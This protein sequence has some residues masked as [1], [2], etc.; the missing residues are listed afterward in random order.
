MST[1]G[2]YY[3]YPFEHFYYLFLCKSRTTH[4]QSGQ[5]YNCVPCKST[6]TSWRSFK[7][8]RQTKHGEK[9]LNCAN[10]EYR[11]NRKDNL[12]RHVKT[13]HSNCKMVSSVIDDILSNV[14]KPAYE[15]LGE[16][17]EV[18]PRVRARNERV[19]MIQAEFRELF[20][21]FEQEVREL[22]CSKKQKGKKRKK[23]PACLVASKRSSRGV[24]S[25]IRVGHLEQ[26]PSTEVELEVSATRISEELSEELHI[27]DAEEDSERV[28]GSAGAG[29]ED[30]RHLEMR[31]TGAEDQ[32]AGAAEESSG[33]SEVRVAGAGEGS[34]EG[35][36]AGL[37]RYGCLPCGMKFRDTLNLRRHVRLVHEARKT[38]VKCPRPWCKSQFLILTEM[39]QHKANCMKVCP[40]P[41]CQRKFVRE[42][43]FASHERYHM[44][45]VRRMQDEV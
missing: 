23:N 27:G 6:F 1:T 28:A 7:R 9:E 26:Q 39:W 3:L 40:F 22:G 41:A 8:H 37:G 18:D 16:L 17:E 31:V 19:A 25:E 30:S 2:R 32:V 20:P 44:T 36:A 29:G 14:V 34:E 4:F 38:P 10:C 42:D 11:T 24:L 43:K 45:M 33:H 5:S 35:A 21:N 12:T 15:D 13:E